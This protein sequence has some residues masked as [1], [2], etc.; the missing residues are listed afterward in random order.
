M[1][2]VLVV[3]MMLLVLIF[4][5]MQ[6]LQGLVS[7]EGRGSGDM[8][9][10]QLRHVAQRQKVQHLASKKPSEARQFHRRRRR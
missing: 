3:K 2:I 4:M 7:D 8:I 1:A 9:S 6:P 10:E 5:L